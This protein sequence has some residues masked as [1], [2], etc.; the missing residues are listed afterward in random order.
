MVFIPPISAQVNFYGVKMTS[1]RLSNSFKP[2]QKNFYTP[3][4]NFWLRPWS[5][6]GLESLRE[7][8][9]ASSPVNFATEEDHSYNANI[10]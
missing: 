8:D 9:C 10:I 2:P 6:T 3:K 5:E 7:G 1:K 4:T